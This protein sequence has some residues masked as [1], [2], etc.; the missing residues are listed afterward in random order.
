M[1]WYVQIR[2]GIFTASPFLRLLKTRP[3]NPMLQ[4]WEKGIHMAKR[5]PREDCLI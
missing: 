1:V 2:S 5:I 4:G 3:K